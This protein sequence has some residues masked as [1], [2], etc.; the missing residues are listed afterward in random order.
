MRLPNAEHAVVEIEKLRDY[1]LNPDHDAGKH[2]ARVFHSALGFRQADAERLR[3]MVLTAAYTEEAKPG[4]LLAHGQM[5]T[6][7]FNVQGFSGAVTIRTGWIV[8]TGTD[9]PRLVTCYVR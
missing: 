5:Y 6:M 9:F 8:A 2:K 4:K 7:D 3:Q 1:A